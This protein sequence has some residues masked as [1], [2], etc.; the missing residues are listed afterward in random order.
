MSLQ[1]FHKIEFVTPIVYPVQLYIKMQKKVYDELKDDDITV[2]ISNDDKT[3]ETIT[4][5]E[6]KR[7]INLI[8]LSQGH[9]GYKYKRMAS[10]NDNLLADDRLYCLI[11]SDTLDL[12]SNI[13]TY[14]FISEESFT[15]KWKIKIVTKIPLQSVNITTTIMRSCVNHA[16][17]VLYFENV[18]QGEHDYVI[19]NNAEPFNLL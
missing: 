11:R 16:I 17:N 6:S 3:Y 12:L 5:G 9:K 4:C 13:D 10:M 19:E 15:G 2:I 14:P 8:S 1:D 7:R 18:I